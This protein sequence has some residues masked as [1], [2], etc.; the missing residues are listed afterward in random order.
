MSKR[1]T[2]MQAGY[3]QVDDELL[4]KIKADFAKNGK[5]RVHVG[6]LGGFDGRQSKEGEAAGNASIGAA[7]EFGVISRNLPARSFLRMPVITQLPAALSATDKQLWHKVIIKKGVIGA[8]E[9]LGAYA[10]DS[11]HLAFETGGFGLWQKLKRATIRRK[12]SSAILIDT[13]QLRQSI[14]AEIF[15][16]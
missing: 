1:R 2:T 16:P 8:L 6:V 10:L 14:T 13:A 9:L 12:K 3:V 7:H 15:G 11:I 5:A 4:Q